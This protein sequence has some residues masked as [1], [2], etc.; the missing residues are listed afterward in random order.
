MPRSSG[1]IPWSPQYAPVKRSQ[2][3]TTRMA[4]IAT[5]A[6]MRPSGSSRGAATS[7][8]GPAVSD[9][10]GDSGDNSSGVVFRRL[11]LRVVMSRPLCLL[12]RA[13]AKLTGTMSAPGPRDLL[14]APQLAPDVV[15]RILAAHGFRDV[16][17][18]DENLQQMAPSPLERQ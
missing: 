18:A 17:A 15:A 8:A 16:R 10:A 13:R 1:C 3:A 11:L 14:L 7:I 4:T 12:R 2:A 9:A 6:A 5:C